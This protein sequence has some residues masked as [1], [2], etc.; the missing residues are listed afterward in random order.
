MQ[1]TNKIV[2]DIFEKFIEELNQDN[3]VE[4]TTVSKISDLLNDGKTITAS[5]LEQIIYGP[6]ETV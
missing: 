3:T 6:D 1:G 2:D 4:K 5:K